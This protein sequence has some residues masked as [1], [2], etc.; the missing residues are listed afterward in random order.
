MK[1]EYFMNVS[2]GRLITV[3][4]GAGRSRKQCEVENMIDERFEKPIQN[5][6]STVS[7][8]TT[9]LDNLIEE[10]MMGDI[11][12][13]HKRNGDVH[14][15]LRENEDVYDTVDFEWIKKKDKKPLVIKSNYSLDKIYKKIHNYADDLFNKVE[16]YSAELANDERFMANGSLE[17]GSV[18]DS[19]F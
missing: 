10:E 13:I 2:F 16:G 4:E 11:L 9:N 14:V 17:M 5:P 1:K 3:V 18:F 6:C 7:G 8:E 12:V 19:I 15:Q